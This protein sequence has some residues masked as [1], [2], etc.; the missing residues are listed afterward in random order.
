M[1][2]LTTSTRLNA[3]GWL[4]DSEY[5]CQANLSVFVI[6]IYYLPNV[7][8][9]SNL[10]IRIQIKKYLEQNLYLFMWH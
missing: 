6:Y 1:D 8:V 10:Q 2:Q 5:H 9:Q 4:K 3:L 7:F